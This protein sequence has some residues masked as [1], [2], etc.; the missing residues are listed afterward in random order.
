MMMKFILDVVSLLTHKSANSIDGVNSRNRRDLDA[1]RLASRCP[2]QTHWKPS[3]AKV[4]AAADTPGYK[5]T[6]ILALGWFN[7]R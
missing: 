7:V 3:L 5:V 1:A 2:G 4:L 6:L